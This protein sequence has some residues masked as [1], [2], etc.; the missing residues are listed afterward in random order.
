ME[1][2]VTK[3]EVSES[4]REQIDGLAAA[5]RE[6]IFKNPEAAS[7]LGPALSYFGS[8]RKGWGNR[9]YFNADGSPRLYMHPAA[10]KKLGNA[11]IAMLGEGGKKALASPGIQQVHVDEVLTEL[12]TNLGANEYIASSVFPRVQVS[13]VTGIYFV[14]NRTHGNRDAGTELKRGLSA[15]ARRFGWDVTRATYQL[16]R[17][18]AEN[19]TDDL[20]REVA[21]DVIGV[22]RRGVELCTG[23]LDLRLEKEVR[24]LAFTAANWSN[25]VTL[26][27]VNQW[28][29]PGSNILAN[30][31]TARIAVY[32]AANKKPNT[33]VMG[34]QVFEALALSDLLL[35]RV[36]YTGTSQSPGAV[37]A[38]MM[39]ALFQVDRII[40][41]TA[42]ENT[43]AE[44]LLDTYTPAFIWGKHALLTYV[45]QSPARED[46]SAGYILT[47]GRAV[48][49]YRE[50]NVT[51]NIIRANEE[52]KAVKTFAGAG[53]T[54]I[55]AVA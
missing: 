10:A 13:D 2:E 24:D 19:E 23:L 14:F 44:T 18:T 45:S 48:D 47:M 3:L 36:K 31:S 16:E 55:N 21:D 39:A 17:Y 34:L 53:Y 1:N 4:Q 41:G 7:E 12:S 28:N 42:I 32:L 38:Q 5:I 27:G 8:P 46:P 29:D 22:D 35:E 40:V 51:S 11:G 9:Q 49:S 20:V 50:E 43:A 37:T 52:W 6:G 54:F 30:L 33:L 26:S 25:T 15:R